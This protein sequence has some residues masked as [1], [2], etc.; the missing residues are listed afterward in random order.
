MES[1]HERIRRS[2]LFILYY[3]L[4]SELGT[5][6]RATAAANAIV[7]HPNPER[8]MVR[9]VAG[10]RETFRMRADEFGMTIFD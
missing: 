5:Y 6:H 8:L 9:G 3:P 1:I 7:V 4:G 10:G 2:A